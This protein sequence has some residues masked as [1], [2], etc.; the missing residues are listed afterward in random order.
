M[1]THR[2]G[3]LGFDKWGAP[4]ARAPLPRLV[5]WELSEVGVCFSIPGFMKGKVR[6][7][8]LRICE[9][10]TEVNAVGAAEGVWFVRAHARQPSVGTFNHHKRFFPYIILFYN[11]L[12]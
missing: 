10:V 4:S 2:R 12:T 9:G 8:A 7:A 6:F 1:P 11:P 5:F 3:Q